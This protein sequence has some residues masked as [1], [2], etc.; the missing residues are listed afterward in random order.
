MQ[1]YLFELSEYRVTYATYLYF[2]K[3]DAQKI[4]HPIGRIEDC[5]LQVAL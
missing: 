3:E 1:A 5:K 4:K 2:I